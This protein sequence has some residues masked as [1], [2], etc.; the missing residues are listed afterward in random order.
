MIN[1]YFYCDD[2]INNY[3]VVRCDNDDGNFLMEREEEKKED[4][5]VLM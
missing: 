1:I 2:K 5:E 4:E 3:H